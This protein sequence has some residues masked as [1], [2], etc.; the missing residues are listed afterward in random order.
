MKKTITTLLLCL[1]LL[2]VLTACGAQATKAEP[3]AAAPA[4]SDAPAAAPAEGE[5]LVLG[6]LVPTIDPLQQI[7]ASEADGQLNIIFSQLSA[8]RQDAAY[9]YAVTD[10]DHN[11]RLELIAASVHPADRSTN[12]HVWQVNEAVTGLEECKVELEEDDSFPDILA[13]AA[14]TFF[15]AA[16]GQWAYLFYDTIVLSDEDVYTVKCSVSLID[17]VLSYK[18]YAIEHTEGRLGNIKVTHLDND[19]KEISAE[20]YDAA[21]FNAFSGWARGSSNFKWFSFDEAS[22]AQLTDSYTVFSGSKRPEKAPAPSTPVTPTPAATPT[23]APIY[24][25]ITKNPTN[26]DRL[27]GENAIFVANANYWTNVTWTFVAPDGREYSPQSFRGF[28]PWCS[29]AGEYYS[30]LSVINVGTEMNW[31][32]VYATFTYENQVG[33]TSTA[34]LYVKDP[35]PSPTVPPTAKPLGHL[36]GTVTDYLMSSVTIYLENGQTVQVLKDVCEVEGSLCVGATCEVY[37]EGSPTAENVYHVYIVGESEPEPPITGTTTG[38]IHDITSSRYTLWVNDGGKATVS[39]DDVILLYGDLAEG[40]RCT[41][42]YEY[43]PTEGNITLVEVYGVTTGLIVPDGAIPEEP[44]GE[45]EEEP[46]ASEEEPEEPLAELPETE[47]EAEGGEGG[48]NG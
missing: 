20:T 40:C 34:Y 46:E 24:M 4:A 9:S 29:V 22:L 15:D 44:E 27:T 7:A 45:P 23:P 5:T 38:T 39:P 18:Q 43:S 14:D 31:W 28:F 19:G 26:E 6:D 12:I 16:S 10:L 36:S 11:G 30:T 8:L 17:G 25:M 13:D 47:V 2:L 21:G 42:Y 41:I 3:T 32:G 35:P 37:Y 33:R 1:A 48:E